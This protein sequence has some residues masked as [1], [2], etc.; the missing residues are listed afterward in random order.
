MAEAARIYIPTQRLTNND[1]LAQLPI[2]SNRQG[3]AF[4]HQQT[5]AK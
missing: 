5:Y 2:V 4:G 3:F 1:I